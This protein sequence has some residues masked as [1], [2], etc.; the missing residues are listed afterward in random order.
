MSSPVYAGGVVDECFDFQSLAV[1]HDT[2]GRTPVVE[3]LQGFL[4]GG[5]GGGGGG[6]SHGESGY[7]A[8]WK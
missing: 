7:V 4:A 2:L 3:P 5:G 1:V 8:R 6:G